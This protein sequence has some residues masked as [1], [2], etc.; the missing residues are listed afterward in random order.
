MW[1]KPQVV[2][3]EYF[4]ELRQFDTEHYLN[5]ARCVKKFDVIVNTANSFEDDV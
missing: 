5:N 2:S 4:E 1:F 3:D